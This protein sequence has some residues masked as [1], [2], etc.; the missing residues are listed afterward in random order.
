VLLAQLKQASE[1]RVGEHELGTRRQLVLTLVSMTKL[2]NG[3]VKELE[4]QI[5]TAIR[6]HP[7]GPILLS[8][9]KGTVIT[10]AELLAEIGDCRAPLHNP[11]CARRRRQPGRGGQRVRQTQDR[12]V[13]LGLRQA[14]SP[15]D[16]TP[17]IGPPAVR[18][19]GWLVTAW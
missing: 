14:A 8:L 18:A 7:D 19:G 11:R 9:F 17:L 1:G 13:S 6:E 2:A 4:R 12:D 16:L 10:A 5:A 3:Q 15:G